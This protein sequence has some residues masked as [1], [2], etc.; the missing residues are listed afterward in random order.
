MVLQY[1]LEV[2]AETV[3]ESV[4]ERSAIEQNFHDVKEVHGAGEQQV[5]N[6]WCNV[7][8]WNLCLWL[9]TIVELW[10]WNRSGNTLKQRA[11]RPWHDVSRRASHADR[12]KTLKKHTFRE[13]F[14]QLPRHQCVAGKIQQLFH[15]LTKLVN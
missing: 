14:P 1:G 3:I 11:D 13:T 4:A 12:L 10:A 5:R 6:V 8:C 2:S 15:A 9:H 7:A